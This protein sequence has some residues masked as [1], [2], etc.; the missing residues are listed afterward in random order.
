MRTKLYLVPLVSCL[1]F[2]TNI[3]AKNNDSIS[4]LCKS[5]LKNNPK[6]NSLKYQEKAKK[7]AYEQ[8]I[9]QYKPKLSLSASAGYNRYDYKYPTKTLTYKDTLYQYS[10]IV[11]QPIY[12]PKILNKITDAKI[13][14]KIAIAKKEDEKAKLTVMISQTV[15][16]LIR[17]Q[18]IRHLLMKKVKLYDKAY[19]KILSKY[20]LRLANNSELH[21]ANARLQKALS[22]LAQANQMFEYTKTNLKL[23]TKITEI[24]ES[25]FNKS[26]YIR[27]IDK[28]YSTEKLSKLKKM[29]ENNTQMTLSKLYLEIAH[30]EI[31]SRKVE[32][33]PTLD[34]KLSYSDTDTTDSITR[35]NDMRAMIE[36][37]FPI[38]QGGYVSDRVNEALELYNAS[39]EDLKNTK[40]ENTISLEKYWQQIRSGLQTYHAKKIAQNAAE[41]YYQTAR[42]AY[43]QGV[44]SLTDAYLAEADYYDSQVQVIN[45]A[46]DL[47]NTILN[48]YYI[49][50][51][52]TCKKIEE[53]EKNYL[54]PN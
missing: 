53:F 40:I 13:R 5:G 18:Q 17:L 7:Y 16:E 52:A 22:D 44:Q 20:N 3:F 23:L 27:Q 29:I 4:E 36:L 42:N 50:G 34:L 11:Q 48:I 39:Q 49:T 37:S 45:S 30:N 19:N 47:L 2:V 41:T 46:A 12:R 14:E 24:T 8:S 9:D 21:Q 32:R 38:Y 33:Y 25:I 1:I 51:N 26:Y 15:V 10:A 35:R 54:I 28:K 31:N 6:I 43:K